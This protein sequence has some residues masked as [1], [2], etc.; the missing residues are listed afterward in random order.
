MKKATKNRIEFAAFWVFLKT[1][2]IFP[3][4]WKRWILEHTVIFGGMV[5][6]VRKKIARHNLRLVYH[7][8]TPTE[9][10]KMLREI[11]RHLGFSTAEM[12]FTP[13][14][15][16]YPHINVQGLEHL[17]AARS[18]GRGVILSTGHIGN[19]EI[20][21]HYLSQTMPISVIYKGMRN[22]LLGEYTNNLRTKG[23]IKLIPMKQALRY[24]LKYLKQQYVVCILMD[25]NA[26]KRGVL[27]DFLGHPASAFTG[28]AKFSIKTGAPIVPAYPI[29][30]QDGSFTL[31]FEPMLDPSRYT[32]SPEDVHAF[33]QEIS[34]NL[35]VYIR[36]YPEQWFWVHRRWRG[37]A[38]AKSTPSKSFTK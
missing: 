20:A 15:S 2:G 17:E 13:P 12:Y 10:K 23:T 28:T 19:W 26:G 38:K 36:R 6:G 33:T 8:M 3:Y 1:F 24:V 37:A 31:Y 27:I 11:Y 9:E 14:E 29:R 22:K 7:Q 30:E 32:N 34:A 35:E 16:L 5:L 4:A 21:G 18:L 25:Q